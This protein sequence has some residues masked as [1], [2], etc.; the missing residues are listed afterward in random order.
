MVAHQGKAAGLPVTSALLA[1]AA[2]S[3][4]QQASTLANAVVAS[5]VAVL[6]VLQLPPLFNHFE[7]A[8]HRHKAN[9]HHLPT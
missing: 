9:V 5:S 2:V 4:A 8:V 6:P 3:V 1:S 7:S